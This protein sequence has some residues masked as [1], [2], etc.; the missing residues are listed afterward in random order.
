MTSKGIARKAY[1][2]ITFVITLPL[3]V[4]FYY[5]SGEQKQVSLLE[6]ERELTRISLALAQRISQ[7]AP[8]GGRFAN[9]GPLLT[10]AELKNYYQP[11][12]DEI[13][14][15]YP[16]YKLGIY[17]HQVGR[18]IAVYPPSSWDWFMVEDNPAV[19][20]VYY[21]GETVTTTLENVKTDGEPSM[22]AV[23]PIYQSG[24]IVG[25]TWAGKKIDSTLKQSHNSFLKGIFFSFMAWLL[26][27]CIVWKVFQKLDKAL[28]SFAEQVTDETA[29]AVE[30]RDFPQLEPLFKTVVSLR[31]DLKKETEHYLEESRTFKQ[32][33][34]LAPL[35]IFLVDKDGILK[36]YNQAF[37]Q[38][39]SGFDATSAINVPYRGFAESTDRI[40]EETVVMRALRGEEIHNEYS[41]FIGRYWLNN[42]LPL[43]NKDGQITGAIAICND[44]TDHEKLRKEMVRLDRLNIV[45]QMA[46]SVA[47][48]VRNPMTVA[49]GYIQSLMKKTGMTYQAQFNTVIEELD[50]ANHIISDF[51][52]LARDKYVEKEKESLTKIIQDIL[53]LIESEALTRNVD[54]AISLD[55]NVPLLLLNSEEIKQLILNLTMNALDAME[56]LKDGIL[57]ITC[58]YKKQTGNVELKVSDTGCGMPSEAI[59]RIFEPFYTTKK[60][61]SGLG[62]SVCKNIVERHGGSIYIQSSADKGTSF[63]V[64]LPLAV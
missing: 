28:S 15:M 27:M 7:T 43:K 3:C 17:H 52:S 42:A 60:N 61:G 56:G 49:R 11:L 8:S 14:V 37:L 10:A 34:E 6:D 24:E 48:E 29:S 13:A 20:K 50:R 47:H 23:S 62:L 18:A 5:Y 36:A 2:I 63:I 38:Y 54:C 22:V 39:H 21:R 55:P 16:Q 32:L 31:E 51:L 33:I 41:F 1:L 4:A 53:P 12:V 19:Q 46:A 9:S 44:I 26:L 57:T 64:S 58:E 59:E 30:F 35:P 45:G 25:F 40:L